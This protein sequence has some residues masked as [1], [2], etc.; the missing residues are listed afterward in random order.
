MSEEAYLDEASNT[1][2][3]TVHQT[4]MCLQCLPA[5]LYRPHKPP[6]SGIASM[7]WCS[8]D[9][10]CHAA[11]SFV[12]LQVSGGDP[13]SCYRSNQNQYSVTMCVVRGFALAGQ[14]MQMPAA[15]HWI[16]KIS[17]ISPHDSQLWHL[18]LSCPLWVWLWIQRDFVNPGICAKFLC[19][20][21]SLFRHICGIYP[22]D[23]QKLHSPPLQ[24]RTWPE[25]GQNSTA[26][27][28]EVHWAVHFHFSFQERASL[29][30][31]R[32]RQVR[33]TLQVPWQALAQMSF[34]AIR[35]SEIPP[36]YRVAIH[37]AMVQKHHCD[38]RCLP[39]FM[40]N[41]LAAIHEPSM[42]QKHP[43]K[44]TTSPWSS[45]V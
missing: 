41:M 21:H 2:R 7:P 14:L 34:S 20:H 11:L 38:P 24:W 43:A 25:R 39:T 12:P 1:L 44:Y 40:R 5:V 4:A 29:L 18:G 16:P 31:H 22:H 6:E 17:C 10:S 26:F 13:S 9:S 37:R 32:L 36:R 19:V 3:L 45:D 33:D 35:K 27:V 28:E 42:L 15:A 23:P 30:M 8:V